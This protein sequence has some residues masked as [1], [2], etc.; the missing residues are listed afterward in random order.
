[1][2]SIINYSVL[3]GLMFLH[4]CLLPDLSSRV[5]TSEMGQLTLLETGVHGSDRC[6]NSQT[7]GSQSKKR[8]DYI[9]SVPQKLLLVTSNPPLDSIVQ[10]LHLASCRIQLFRQYG[11]ILDVEPNQQHWWE[12][13]RE[14]Q[15]AGGSH[16]GGKI[17]DLR[18]C[19]G[20]HPGEGPVGRH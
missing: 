4:P 1:M 9:K 2:K 10:A 5:R 14:L 7:S 3:V 12:S 19:G 8:V 17:G 6:P 13:V 11:I 20:N 18:D 16:E 15:D